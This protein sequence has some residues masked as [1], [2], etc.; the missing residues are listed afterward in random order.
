MLLYTFGILHCSVNLST[1]SI[2]FV[3]LVHETVL[4]NSYGSQRVKAVLTDTKHQQLLDSLIQKSD[5]VMEDETKENFQ[6]IIFVTQCC[7]S[8][9]TSNTRNEVHEETPRRFNFFQ[10]FFLIHFHNYIQ[11]N[12]F[13]PRKQGSHRFQAGH[14]QT[15]YRQQSNMAPKK[16][17]GTRKQKHLIR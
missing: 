8:Q 10:A 3:C 15:R 14:H 1:N 12:T 5:L 13:H 16:M 6:T 11:C 9:Q 2:H 17:T 4:H 7:N